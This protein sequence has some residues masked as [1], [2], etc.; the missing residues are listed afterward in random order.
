MTTYTLNGMP[1]DA[2]LGLLLVRLVPLSSNVLSLDAIPE[3]YRFMFKHGDIVYNATSS[4]P[5]LTLTREPD[6]YET[7]DSINRCM[8][9]LR[10]MGRDNPRQLCG[11]SVCN[12]EE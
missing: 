8:V 7:G 11:K 4:V 12:S 3:E 5:V 6:C 10:D 1:I 2:D 9:C